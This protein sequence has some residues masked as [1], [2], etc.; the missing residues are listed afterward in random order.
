MNIEKL[1]LLI[2]EITEA[3]PEFNNG[4]EI[5]VK[6]KQLDLNSLIAQ[7]DLN[8]IAQE[9]VEAYGAK[10]VSTELNS[11]KNDTSKVS[12]YINGEFCCKQIENVGFR[13]GLTGIKFEFEANDVDSNFLQNIPIHDLLKNIKNLNSPILNLTQLENKIKSFED[14]ELFVQKSSALTE[15]Y[16]HNNTKTLEKF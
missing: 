15:N 14:Y 11:V 12:K 4:L 7:I 16:A 3:T 6:T 13:V 8:V 10:K 1:E 9:L 2:E 5:R